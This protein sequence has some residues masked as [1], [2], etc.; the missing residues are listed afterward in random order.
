MQQKKAWSLPQ[1]V[2]YGD[3]RALTLQ[4]RKDFSGG[5]GY[6]A[7]GMPMGDCS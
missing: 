7:N 3:L 1:L 4:I 6:T 5:D 2:V